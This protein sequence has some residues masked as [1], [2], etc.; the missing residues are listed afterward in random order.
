MLSHQ[1]VLNQSRI[2]FRQWGEIWER[3]AKE[4]GEKHRLEQNTVKD[5]IHKGIGKTLVCVGL[6]PSFEKKFDILK[7]YRDNVDIAIVD[8]ALGP[9]IDGGIK[10]DFV[11]LSDAVISYEEW[12][13][14]WVD[15]TDGI[16]LISNVTANPK[17]SKNWRGPVYFTVN[18][19]NIE[20]E[21]IYGPLSG[22]DDLIPA[23]SNVGNSIVVFAT[24]FMNYDKYLLLG[25]EFVFTDDHTYYAF[26]DT[27]KRYWMRHGLSIDTEG[28]LAYV[29]QNLLFTC[30]WLGDYYKAEL[31]KR[32]IKV[33]NC[34]GGNILE[35]PSGNLERQMKHSGTRKLTDE[36]RK[37]VL[38]DSSYSR[39]IP[40]SPNAG[41][42]LNE[43]FGSHKYIG[44][45]TVKYYKPEVIEWLN[46]RCA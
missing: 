25:Y 18:K 16:V 24:Q 17:W 20:T 33:I 12:C 14:P 32:G 8:K 9:C 19:D 42:E 10:P 28:R 44:D 4:N 3:H 23:S 11:F 38:R 36:E 27:D 29:T 45:I 46:Q 15:K 31:L 39:T 2:A 7:K 30:R 1:E 35:L 21:K 41:V 22:C 6:A 40:A 37:M 43:F 5:F 26:K 34:S 13:E